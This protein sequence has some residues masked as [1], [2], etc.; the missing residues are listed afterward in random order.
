LNSFLCSLNRSVLG[1]TRDGGDEK[2]ANLEKEIKDESGVRKV[3]R[4]R[5]TRISRPI[6]DEDGGE[7]EP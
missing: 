5:Q 7:N 4:L 6:Q 3:R 2:W 1:R